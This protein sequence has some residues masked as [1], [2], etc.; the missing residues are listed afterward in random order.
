MHVPYVK[1]SL[2]MHNMLYALDISA[3]VLIEQLS[4]CFVHKPLQA[5]SMP[6]A[7]VRD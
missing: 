2:V 5:A 1:M 6:A 7:H 3:M 4:E